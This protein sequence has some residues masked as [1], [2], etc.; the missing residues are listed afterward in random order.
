MDIE[1]PDFLTPDQKR[2]ERNLLTTCFRLMRDE[3]SHYEKQAS[4]FLS[5]EFLSINKAEYSIEYSIQDG[6]YTSKSVHTLYLEARVTIQAPIPTS[7]SKK[8][9]MLIELF[10]QSEAGMITQNS[11]ISVM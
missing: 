9:E 6:L 2:M 3:R 8:I 11:S 10:A 4:E 5:T 7:R 1:D